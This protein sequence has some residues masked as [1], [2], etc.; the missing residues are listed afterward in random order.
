MTA[1]I[2]ATYTGL[3]SDA[4]W[5]IG[6]DVGGTGIKAA[7]VDR[8]SGTLVTLRRE[9][10]TPPGG[11]P[12]DIVEVVARTVVE[13]EAEI[14]DA[15]RAM[16]LGMAAPGDVAQARAVVA[17]SAM[18]AED[19]PLPPLPIGV[20]IPSVVRGG[21]ALTAANIDA[22]WIGAD[23][24]ALFAKA[25][26]RP[27]AVLNDAD[28]AGVAEARFGAAREAAGVTLLLTFGTGIG[29]A[30]LHD[31]VLVPNLELGHLHLDGHADIER[32]ASAKAIEREGISQAEWASRA[33]RLL[34]HLEVLFHPDRFVLG[35]GISAVAERYLPFPGVE[36]PVVPARCRADAGIVGAAAS[37]VAET[38]AESGA[39]R[40]DQAGQAGRSGLPG[41]DRIGTIGLPGNDRPG[42]DRGGLAGREGEGT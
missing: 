41:N 36:A 34:Q 8:A 33:A 24:G 4:G 42:F 1:E 19:A 27:V 9:I 26:G 18:V 25:I 22:S 3:V 35:G 10:P 32:F 21:V 15:R 37:A 13:L 17:A 14:A 39:E 12:A 29:S 40:A 6:V 20:A 5:A 11:T 16:A 2:A 7:V 30:L 28:A 31:G 23:A 38:G